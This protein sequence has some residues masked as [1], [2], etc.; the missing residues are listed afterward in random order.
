MLVRTSISST[1]S[2][3]R[4]VFV[5]TR[6]RSPQIDELLGMSDSTGWSSSHGARLAMLRVLAAFEYTTLL[7]ARHAM[8]SESIFILA[9]PLTG[10]NHYGFTITRAP[11]SV[12]VIALKGCARTNEHFEQTEPSSKCRT[13][14]AC[15]R[16]AS[17]SS[18]SLSAM[19][20]LR[21]A[22]AA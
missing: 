10:S 21:N 7:A 2:N 1:R 4:R 16:V 17:P 12:E 3:R 15:A 6:L 19:T 14:S 8:T 22:K 13:S 18:S 11:A 20:L 5:D 9:N